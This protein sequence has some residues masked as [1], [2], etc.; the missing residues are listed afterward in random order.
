MTLS[1]S[2]YHEKLKS[3]RDPNYSSTFAGYPPTGATDFSQN[4]HNSIVLNSKREIELRPDVLNLPQI[5]ILLCK[6]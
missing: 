1:S 2:E 6:N 3:E 4:I 5:I